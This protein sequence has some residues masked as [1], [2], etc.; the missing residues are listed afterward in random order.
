[1]FRNY[2]RIAVRNLRRNKLHAI[3]NILGL[4]AGISVC[5]LIFLVIRFETSFDNFHKQKRHIYRV[6]SVFKEP[7]GIDYESGVAFPTGPALRRDYPELQKVASILSLGGDAQFKIQTKSTNNRF[8]LQGGVF[9]AEP[10]FFGM[11]DFK[12]LS[13]N[14]DN[15]LREPNTILLTKSVAE[16]QFGNWQNA[17]GKTLVVDN[18]YDVKITGILEDM[19]SNTDFPIKAV[20]SYSTLK[21]IGFGDKLNDWK[22]T[23]AQHYCFVILPDN[24][25][26]SKFD[27]N[28]EEFTNKY[29]PEGYRNEGMTLLPLTKMHYDTRYTIF[30]RRS[31]SE[32]LI[33]SLGLIC[34]FVLLNACI[35]FIN[36]ATAI[37]AN[38]SKEVGIRKV[39]GSTRI[40]L[41]FQF[42]SETAIVII[43]A[44]IIAVIVSERSLTFFNRLLSI[45]ISHSFVND[46]GI[47][48][49]LFIIIIALTILAGLYPAVFLSRVN[50][51]AALKNL[52][53]STGRSGSFTLRRILVV[54]QFTISQVLIIGVLV[55]YGQMN[56]FRNHPM[57]FEKDNI[58]VAG[59]PAW[60]SLSTSKIGSLR[61]E[62]LGIPGVTNVSYSFA[63]P[64]DNNDW[65]ANI[66]Y[67]GVMNRDFGVYLK[68]ADV[69]YPR[70]FGLQMLAGH[71]YSQ[72]DTPR[73]YVVNEAFVQKLGIQNVQK[74]I[75]SKLQIYNVG[76]TGT[77]VGVVKN[78]NVASLRDS[79]SPVVMADWKS[80]YQTANIKL[81]TTDVGPVISEMARY[82]KATFPDFT[83][84]YHFFD[85]S[86]ANY[87][88]E[89]A[90]MSQLFKIF[91]G[92]A[93]CISCLGLFGLVSFI[94]VQKRREVAI[95]KTLGA[96]TYAIVS[97]FSKEYSLLVLIAFLIASPISWYFMHQWLQNYA[98]HVPLSISIFLLALLSSLTIAWLTVG[99]K[100]IRAALTN[101]VNSLRSE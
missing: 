45:D 49:L 88:K 30:T 50:P 48:A 39:L 33:I 93:I 22:S 57:G 47:I 83:F 66:I 35:N 80:S 3:I 75:G 94:I 69:N 90:Q 74:V 89:E 76:W 59:V 78:F 61:N 5:I 96:S 40:S 101:P 72:S 81:G 7:T 58:V 52:T 46:L 99:Y 63:S 2:F 60:D 23:F 16:T 73:N 20:I 67:N 15:A 55:V 17:I 53:G 97:L 27:K 91:A 24:Y 29:K 65:N 100:S 70:L 37:A 38:R 25:P 28:L 9:Y 98:Y 1:M 44:T 14:K 43:L 10:E 56:Y 77:I 82:W 31:F 19:P 36:L 86:I 42:L 11:F 34:L 68:W 41:I 18:Q 71:F 8:K 12:W 21:N 51:I 85:E 92:I 62:L 84:E 54:L 13:G 4:A 87:Y 32:G 6:V 64:I 79:I 95:R 26:E